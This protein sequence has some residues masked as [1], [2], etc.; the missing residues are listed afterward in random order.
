MC[1]NQLQKNDKHVFILFYH[2]G[3][4]LKKYHK[5]EETIKDVHES[6]IYL[7]S[8]RHQILHLQQHSV[9]HE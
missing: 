4:F 1:H 6:L 7:F 8:V 5:H 9:N 3:L 2:C